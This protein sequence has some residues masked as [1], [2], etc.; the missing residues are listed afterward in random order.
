[1][2][3]IRS[4]KVS[5]GH[6]TYLMQC[7]ILNSIMQDPAWCIVC[8]L[9]PSLEA[10]SAAALSSEQKEEW[11]LEEEELVSAKPNQRKEG[12]APSQLYPRTNHPPRNAFV[13]KQ[14][15]KKS[16]DDWKVTRLQ[17][18]EPDTIFS[19]LL[20]TM[21][22]TYQISETAFSASSSPYPVCLQLRDQEVG[23]PKSASSSWFC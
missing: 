16:L 14:T 1:M 7:Y 2:L 20:A 4:F 5:L 17:I 21:T 8:A 22:S 12:V 11:A 15:K 3:C 9:F 13:S 19:K 6:A 23:R 18:P 10:L